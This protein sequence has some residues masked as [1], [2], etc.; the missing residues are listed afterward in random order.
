MTESTQH[1]ADWRDRLR[2]VVVNEML[3]F[4]RKESEFRRKDREERA[5]ELRLPLDKL[6]L[7]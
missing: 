7:H 1:K 5:A 4:E 2:E 6:D 3:K